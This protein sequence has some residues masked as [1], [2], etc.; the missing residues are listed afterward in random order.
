MLSHHEIPTPHPTLQASPQ[1]DS[2]TYYTPASRPG[3]INRA[4][5]NPSE[6][7]DRYHYSNSQGPNREPQV[8][9][10][11]DS[12]QHHPVQASLNDTEDI[13]KYLTL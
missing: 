4:D 10:T 11:G 9:A 1:D 12:Q 3:G 2:S 6:N 5:F 13:F 7:V 8:A